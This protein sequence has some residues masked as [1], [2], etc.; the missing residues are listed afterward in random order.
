MVHAY[1]FHA[2]DWASIISTFESRYGRGFKKVVRIDS[3][4]AIIPKLMPYP[5]ENKPN[6]SK[7]ILLSRIYRYP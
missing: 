1:R 4:P 3:M 2:V 5:A 6:S 7:P